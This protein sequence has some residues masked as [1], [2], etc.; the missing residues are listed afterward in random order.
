MGYKLLV[1]ATVLKS[2]AARDG[3]DLL[4]ILSAEDITSTAAYVFHSLATLIQGAKW[5]YMIAY[6]APERATRREKAIFGIACL[7]T[8]ASAAGVVVAIV[9]FATEGSPNVST[10]SRFNLEDRKD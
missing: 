1:S 4:Q 8:A 6:R 2:L 5:A 9:S 3:R 7:D 10:N